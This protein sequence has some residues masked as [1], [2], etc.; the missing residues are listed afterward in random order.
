VRRLLPFPGAVVILATPAVAVAAVYGTRIDL[1]V[2][3]MGG[4]AVL[5]SEPLYELLMPGTGLPFTYPP[6]A[7]MLFSPLALIPQ[8]PAQLLWGLLLAGCLAVFVAEAARAVGWRPALHRPLVAVGIAATVFAAEP[9]R[10]N[11]SFGQ[12]NIPLAVLVL[13]DLS[14]RTGRVP[15]GVAT[16]LAG[17]V[18]LTPMILVPYLLAV[19][20]TRDA[21]VATVTFGVCSTSAAL[22]APS[23]SATFWTRT[24]V[25]PSYVSGVPYSAN[26]SLSGLFTRLAGH[27][28]YD[29]AWFRVVVVGTALAGL[30]LAAM[31]TRGDAPLGWLVCVLTGLLVSPVSWS[32]HWVWW[33]LAVVWLLG[34][35]RPRWCRV[36]AFGTALLLVASPIWWVPNAGGREYGWTGWQLVAGNAYVIAAFAFLAGVAVAAV[37]RPGRLPGIEPTQTRPVGQAGLGAQARGSGELDA[38]AVEV[39][40]A[41]PASRRVTTSREPGEK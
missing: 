33:L 23:D 20:R 5:R 2:Y 41:V 37:R 24:V 13:A 26:Q 38:A 21:A 30:A 34:P 25:D 8:R 36:A 39:H 35:A 9:V 29:E 10:E 17:A 12:I 40:E 28:V 18:K 15:V 1:A 3:R 4:Q 11:L 31:V 27:P 14:R 7:A 32:H 16:G 22:V 6:F 19:R